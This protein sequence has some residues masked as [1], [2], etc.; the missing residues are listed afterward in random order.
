MIGPVGTKTYWQEVDDTTG[1]SGNGQLF[2]LAF[3]KP[4]PPNGMGMECAQGGENSY[5]EVTVKSGSLEVEY[6]DENGDTVVDADG[7]TPCGPYV[8]TH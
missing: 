8:L 2:S 5:A 4:P 1:G 6:K 7:T 3:F